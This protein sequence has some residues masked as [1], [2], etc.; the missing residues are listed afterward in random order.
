[1]TI[2]LQKG[3]RSDA[4]LSGMITELNWDLNEET[5]KSKHTGNFADILK[6]LYV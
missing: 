3:Q 1:M 2:N 5:G 4:G 6:S